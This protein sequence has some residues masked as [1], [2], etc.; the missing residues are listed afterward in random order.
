MIS[1]LTIEV[2]DLLPVG[3]RGTSQCPGAEFKELLIQP[4]ESARGSRN[5]RT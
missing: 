1:W 2:A 3:G 4:S 5:E